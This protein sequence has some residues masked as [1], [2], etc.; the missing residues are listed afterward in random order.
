MVEFVKNFFESHTQTALISLGITALAHIFFALAVYFDTKLNHI[1]YKTIIII[2]TALFG[3]V[4]TALYFAFRRILPT[5]VPIVCT[6]CGK[7]APKGAKTCP[8]CGNTH[9]APLQ[10]EDVGAIKTRIIALLAAAIVLFAFDTWYTQYSPWAPDEDEVIEEIYDNGYQEDT[11]RFEYVENGKAVYYDRDGKTYGSA[12][13][14]VLYDKDSN[15]F[16]LKGDKYVC[17]SKEISCKA[18]LVDSNG[19]I[20]DAEEE[21]GNIPS[22]VPFKTSDGTMYYGASDVSWNKDGK[23][24][25]TSNGRIM[26]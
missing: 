4:P 11:V 25:Y 21:F 6:K 9:F 12:L 14:V 26:N 15:P 5:K 7:K 16:V 2:A 19:F 3:A 20:V 18:A 1:K 13:D 10:F 17:P 24:V 22:S 8:K 23:M